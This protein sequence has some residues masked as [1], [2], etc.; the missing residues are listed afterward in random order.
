ME[1]PTSIELTSLTADGLLAE[2]EEFARQIGNHRADPFQ[3]RRALN[4]TARTYLEATG[5]PEVEL[6]ALV[7]TLAPPE[8]WQGMPTTGQDNVFALLIEFQDHVHTNAASDI[9][10]AL[11]GSPA[12]GSPY[13]SLAEYYRRASYNQ[14]EI[15]GATLGWYKTSGNRSAIP[16][17]TAGREALIREAIQHFDAQGHDFS[18]YDN[19]HDGVIDYF[20]VFWTG[21]DTGWAT[22]WW[23]YQTDFSDLGFTVDGVRLGKY[24]WQ[25]EG[26]PVG[27][28]FTPRVAIHETGHALGLPD[29][30]DYNG[31]L[32]PD[33]GVGGADM[34]DAN[35][36][37][38]NCFSKWMLDWLTPTIIGSGS[39]TVTLNPSG[40]SQEC[41][42]VWPG[43]D[44][45]EIFSE[46]YMV[47]NRQQVGNDVHFPAP[48]LMIWHIDA[49][50]DATGADFA[51]DNSYTAHKYVRLMEADGQEDIEANRG[52]D[53]GDLY[54]AGRTFGPTTNPSSAKYDGTASNVEV[55]DIT[56]SGLTMSATIGGAP[57]GPDIR[58]EDTLNFGKVKKG[59]ASHRPLTIHNDGTATLTCT[60]DGPSTAA[61]RC[62]ADTCGTLQPSI[63]PGSSCSLQVTFETSVKGPHTDTIVI[64][65]DDPDTP[66]K[67]V[68]LTGVVRRGLP[69]FS[70]ALQ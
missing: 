63:A 15:D 5:M 30:Y 38:H 60:I 46:L 13:E 34:M 12:A 54:T 29:L 48:G 37:D 51:F 41:V 8:D 2:R 10:E 6:D 40:T 43:L 23:G 25:W 4:Q 11:F 36:F 49:S 64:H 24:S 61:F 19:N 56:A 52:F 35:Q 33:G 69:G 20:L 3:L 7:P 26:R 32:G 16:R 28:T 27:A 68:T 70:R 18:Q 67:T 47:Q 59:E 17:T 21:P 62:L 57:A 42:A 53:V 22:F 44:S 65:S 66:A 55:R 45:G 50:L 39:Q 14:L 31:N 58:V 9:H 1:P